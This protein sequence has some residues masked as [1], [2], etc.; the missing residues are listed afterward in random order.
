[1]RLS[2]SAEISVDDI[3]SPDGTRLGQARHTGVPTHAATAAEQVSRN[4]VGRTVAE[5]ERDLIDIRYRPADLRGHQ[6]S[7]VSDLRAE[8]HAQFTALAEYRVVARMC[9]RLLP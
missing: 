5:V 1:M 6:R 8:R 4:L 3:L 9:R 7:R 2:T